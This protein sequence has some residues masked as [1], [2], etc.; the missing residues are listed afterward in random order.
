MY[1]ENNAETRGRH[2]WEPSWAGKGNL[3]RLS[4]YKTENIVKKTVFAL[5][6]FGIT[7]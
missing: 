6:C 5:V 4:R 3:A 2:G 7:A 1:F